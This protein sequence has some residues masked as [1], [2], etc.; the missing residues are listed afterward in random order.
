M[1]QVVK[2]RLQLLT[3]FQ[4]PAVIEEVKQAPN[5]SSSAHSGV[6]TNST[7]NHT[8]TK[9][10]KSAPANGKN[11]V[12][13]LAS[14]AGGS[15]TTAQSSTNVQAK[16]IGVASS[17]PTM[18]GNVAPSSVVPRPRSDKPVLSSIHSDISTTPPSHSASSS[19]RPIASPAPASVPVASVNAVDRRSAS[20]PSASSSKQPAQG[21]NRKADLPSNK[22]PNAVGSGVEKT[23]P[24]AF[25]DSP[26][27][28]QIA[29]TTTTAQAPANDARG[30]SHT[31]SSIQQQ[32]VIGG[33]PTKSAATPADGTPT[34][35]ENATV[36]SNDLASAQAASSSSQ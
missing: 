12:T 27:L 34:P 9:S 10:T 20:S 28:N 19:P 6:K 5:S 15:T 21:S 13:S 16:K 31:P 32:N 35:R 2:K 11:K 30:I 3:K 18:K 14:S 29:E 7:G 26:S 33:E 4:T 1:R 22:V 24:S 23:A 17:P 25:R 36:A 8:V